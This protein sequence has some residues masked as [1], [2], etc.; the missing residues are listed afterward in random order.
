MSDMKELRRNLN[1]K[2]RALIEQMTLE[3]KVYLLSGR[4]SMQKITEDKRQGKHF[5]FK[6]YPAGGNKTLGI[7]ELKFC[8]GPR[9]VVCGN[10]HSTCFP[11]S[12]MRG[13]TFDPELEEEIGKAMGREARAYGANIFGGACVNLPYHPGWGRNQETYGEDSYAIGKMGA[14]L[15][16][17][18][19]SQGVIAAVKHFAMN[20]MEDNRFRVNITC[21][22][23]T[24]REVL[25]PHFKDCIDAGAGAVMSAFN[26]VDGEICGQSRHL[27]SE[28]L[29]EDWEYD[30][31]V[32]S[33]FFWGIN[34]TEKAINAGLDVEMSDTRFFGKNLV[35]AVR[36]GKVEEARIDD[37]ALRVVAD[38]LAAEAEALEVLGEDPKAFD[39]SVVGCYEH[40]ALALKAAEEG[41]VLLK[42]ENHTL[43]LS[44]ELRKIAII[45][46]LATADNL[47]DYG[48][49]RVYPKHVVNI[50]S[51]M[52]REAQNTEIIY[53]DGQDLNHL[54][55]VCAESDAVVYVVGMS[56]QDE[57]EYT[58]AKEASFINTEKHGGDRHSLELHPED[59]QMIARGAAVNENSVV[60]L[61]G[62]GT[63]LLSEWEQ[64]VPAVIQAFYPGQGGGIAL[65]EILFGDVNPGG[66]LPFVIPKSEDDLPLVDWQADE[67]RY[68]YYHGYRLL[69][70][71]G[72]AV[73]RPYGF[74]LSYT[75]FEIGEASFVQEDSVIKVS[76]SVK[77]TGEREG[78]EVLQVYAGF[79]HSRVDRPV[80]TLVGF[81]RVGLHPGE[82]KRVEIRCPI[83]RLSYYDE[84]EKSF[85]LEDMEYEFYVGNS[86]AADDLRK[87]SVKI[88]E[89]V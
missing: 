55:R 29:K 38:A 89:S 25:L 27:L 83:S 48:S 41:M 14:A 73:S 81:Q 47:G 69:E 40:Q 43:P 82:E 75:T 3:E 28:V 24:E 5:N 19:Q 76:V 39:A 54:E 8:D 51:G 6:P 16:R 22:A 71:E 1:S 13:A 46:K 37:A 66:K 21:D 78:A 87:Y 88:D 49:S 56:A 30:G 61:I 32:I 36:A 84:N 15:V 70:K 34:D 9:G 65:A 4:T 64:K 10:G 86:S 72:A 20:S 74:G 62:G 23:R 77:N 60:V 85:V 50:L 12:V 11:V 42:N 68:E 58:P 2:A 44:K 52:I 17:G 18:I 53:Y 35:E 57:G 31:I 26:K 63:I 7:P 59:R 80:K 67:Q 33:D 79:E 45:G